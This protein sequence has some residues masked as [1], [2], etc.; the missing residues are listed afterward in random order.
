[1]NRRHKPNPGNTIYNAKANCPN[2]KANLRERLLDRHDMAEVFNVS[3][4]TIYN[5]TSQGF[6][7]TIDFPGRTYY[8]A[9]DV[10]KM[11]EAYKQQRVPVEKR[12][13]KK[14]RK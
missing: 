1:M 9:V 6:F 12:G 4:N 10:E 14:K 11:L 8:D 3:L 2:I 7:K 13:R 5:W